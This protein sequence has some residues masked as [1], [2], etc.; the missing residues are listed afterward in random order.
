MSNLNT[1]V[2]DS[3]LKAAYAQWN[4]EGHFFSEDT[5]DFW[6]SRIA[7]KLQKRESDGCIFFLTSEDNFDRS[8]KMYTLRV[9]IP[10]HNGGIKTL[11]FQEYKADD[12]GK[13]KAV[14]K[15]KEF[16]QTFVFNK[17]E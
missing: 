2:S 13:R 16:K 6:G 9:L 4:P 7:T 8:Q 3:D 14:E 17:D 10:K 11:A 5:I 1:S 12:V 15:L